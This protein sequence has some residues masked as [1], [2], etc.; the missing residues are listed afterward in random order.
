MKKQT[1]QT[2]IIDDEPDARDVLRALIGRFCP[3]IEICGEADSVIGALE[4][5]QQMKPSLVFLDVDLH[6]GT[7]FDILDV[8]PNPNFKVVFTTAHDDF[9]LKAFKYRALHYLLKPVDP[10]DLVQV[11]NEIH[12]SAPLVPPDELLLQSPSHTPQGKLLLPTIQGVSVVQA[13][14]IMYIAAD[15]KYTQVVLVSG[16]KIFVS[17]SLKEVEAL[18][19]ESEF[20][21]S[22]QSYIVRTDAIRKIQKNLGG[23][24]LLLKDKTEIPIS[25]RNK[26]VVLRVLGIGF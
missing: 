4:A 18:L 21:R 25:R 26:D 7:G 19:P 5:I 20:L 23:L 2:L 10:Y 11:T 3:N 9:A 16:E 15:E 24:S 1:F 22:H 12:K 13:D 14:E 8:F 6:P 17:H